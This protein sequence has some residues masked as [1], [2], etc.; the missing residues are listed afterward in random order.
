MYRPNARERLGKHILAGAK[1]NNTKT[2]VDR[3]RIS[4]HASLTIYVVFSAWPVR[5]GYK[6]V[7]D[8][9]IEQ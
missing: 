9:S 2:S 8:S 3:Q 6:E 1:A 7:F 5:S 4:K